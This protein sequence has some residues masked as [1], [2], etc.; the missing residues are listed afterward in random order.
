MPIVIAEMRSEEKS[1][2]YGLERDDIEFLSLI[3][4]SDFDGA[5]SLCDRAGTLEDAIADRINEA[6]V[7]GF[8]DVVL[9]SDG[10]KYVIISDYREDIE[11]WLSKI[12]K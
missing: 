10:E 3:F 9:E 7:D 11:N 8:G 12:M 1:D 6:F 5:R 2:T 4:N